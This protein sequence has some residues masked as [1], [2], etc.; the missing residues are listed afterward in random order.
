MKNIS[1]FVLLLCIVSFIS[2]K[3]SGVTVLEEK[4]KIDPS[5]IWINKTYFTRPCV[6]L[7]NY[8][9]FQMTFTKTGNATKNITTNVFK[10]INYQQPIYQIPTFCEGLITSEFF[11]CYTME[12]AKMDGEYIVYL[13]ERV[14][15]EDYL[16]PAYQSKENVSRSEYF[17]KPMDTEIDII[18]NYTIT[19]SGMIYFNFDHELTEGHLPIIH[20]LY[21][22][23]EFDLECHI[24]DIDK[25]IMEC[26]F[27]QKVFPTK[28]TGH[29]KCYT[30]AMMDSCGLREYVPSI[31]VCVVE[32]YY[33]KKK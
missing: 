7:D 21:E 28:E 22:Q 5:V 3:K 26:P 25:K 2:S 15:I 12:E 29:Y 14:Q 10:L 1:L 32:G 13:E 31:S 9:E 6:R 19:P 20:I 17:V 30:G 4:N 24:Y 16:I 23:P 27:T 11:R 8:T 33:T 18:H